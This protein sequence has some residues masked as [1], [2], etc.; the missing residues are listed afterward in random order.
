MYSLQLFNKNHQ[1]L[2]SIDSI[3]DEAFAHIAEPYLVKKLSITSVDEV[4]LGFRKQIL[5][6]VSAL[7]QT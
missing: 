3:R 2:S 6:K 1:L 7:M 4:D 5:A